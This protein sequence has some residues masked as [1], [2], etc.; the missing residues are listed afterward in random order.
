MK[1]GNLKQDEGKKNPYSLMH[2]FFPFLFKKI[3]E[4][5]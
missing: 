5:T 4:P 3:G 1:K 2:I